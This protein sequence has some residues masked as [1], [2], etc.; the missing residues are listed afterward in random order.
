MVNGKPK[1]IMH[2]N[3]KQFPFKIFKHRLE[4]LQGKVESYNKIVE[5]EYISVENI[6]S[7]Y[8]GQAK[9]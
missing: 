6:S 8:E 4:Q 1:K 2:N 7:I 9:R 5:D 3:C